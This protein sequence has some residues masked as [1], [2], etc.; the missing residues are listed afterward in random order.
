MNRLALATLPLLIGVQGC[1][2]LL[3]PGEVQCD[4][5]AD[6]AARGFPEAVCVE[7][8]CVE[9]PAADPVWGCLGH[10]VEPVPDKTKTVAFTMHLAFATDGTSV[11]KATIDVCDKLDLN[12]TGKNPAYPKGLSPGS[13]GLVKLNVIEGFDGFVRIQN[14]DLMASRIYVGR[15]IVTPPKVKEIRLLRP[16]EYAYLANLADKTVDLTRGTAILL[17]L[18]CR[19]EAARGI[20]F[21]S[22]NAD[23]KSAE[24]YLVNQSPATPPAV[25]ATD[26]D[27]FGGF[28]NLPPSSAVARAFLSAG[29]VYVGESSF[30]VLAN[31]I[32]YV[33]VGP[34]P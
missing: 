18:D 8:L 20:H 33:Q 1:T 23:A 10:V 34:T 29:H 25:T 12:C 21:E 28:L 16:Q 14:P 6:C 15:P 2:V 32:S 31:T 17:A 22:K 27:G 19:G 30:Q 5:A 3:A 11:T 26:V 4:S 9:P 13:D 24:F 7:Q